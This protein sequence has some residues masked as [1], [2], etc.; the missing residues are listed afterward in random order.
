M[1]ARGAPPPG[2][3]R[4][5]RSYQMSFEPNKLQ[6]TGEEELTQRIVSQARAEVKLRD[7]LA[8]VLVRIWT[9]VLALGAVLFARFQRLRT[10]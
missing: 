8:F 6:V 2:E 3:Q 4:R 1:L 9:V 7:F 5:E 10:R